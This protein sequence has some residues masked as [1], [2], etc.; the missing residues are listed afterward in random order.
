MEGQNPHLASPCA[1]NS[2]YTLYLG[3]QIQSLLASVFLSELTSFF[4]C[5][6]SQLLFFKHSKLLPTCPLLGILKA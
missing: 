6:T 5:Q 1:Q 2:N 4:L 3:L